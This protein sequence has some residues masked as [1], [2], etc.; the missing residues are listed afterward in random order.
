MKFGF[1]GLGNMGLNL[2]LQLHE[3]GHDISAWNRSPEARDNAAMEGIKVFASIPEL[4]ESLSTNNI[5]DN[6]NEPRIVFMMVSAG[7]AV[8]SILFGDDQDVDKGEKTALI[9]LLA[10]GDVI[11]EA[12]NSHYKDSIRRAK[13]LL[14]KGI[15]Y[16]D[17][18]VSGGVEGARN[19]ACAMVGGHKKTFDL[20]E[21]I[22]KDMCLKDGYGY[23]GESGAGHYV[24]MIHNAIEYGMMQ[25][26]AEGL[27]LLDESEYNPD[28]KMLLRVWNN[29]SII[30]SRLIEFLAKSLE[31]NDVSKLETE[32]GALGTGMWAVHDALERGVPLD[33]IARAVFNRYAS[34][35]TSEFAFKV[36]QAMRAEFG[37]HKGSDRE[38]K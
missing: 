4:I 33:T 1:L 2:V 26:I 32:V 25:S 28:L 6:S 5:K 20:I 9:Y 36:I 35:G 22:L 30:E 21:P 3:K 12:S 10:D 24:K 31:K 16:I 15:H 13:R 34:R 14:E 18:G 8:D 17:M 23:M 29:G 19:G 38:S 37:A 11:V 7:S 27:N